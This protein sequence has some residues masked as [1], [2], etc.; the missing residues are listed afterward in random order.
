MDKSDESVNAS[1]P[2]A[3]T[4]CSFVLRVLAAI[5]LPARDRMSAMDSDTG[6]RLAAFAHIRQLLELRDVLTAGDL[7]PGFQFEGSRI[8]PQRGIS[9]R[10]TGYFWRSKCATPVRVSSMDQVAIKTGRSNEAKGLRVGI[11]RDNIIWVCHA[12]AG[13][14]SGEDNQKSSRCLSVFR[15]RKHKLES[16]EQL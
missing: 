8:D 16:H 13:R 9:R 12:R 7:K 2:A 14:R 3:D 10:E 1:S 4:L 15:R 5:L 11:V 6:M